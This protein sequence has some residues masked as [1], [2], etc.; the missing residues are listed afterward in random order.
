MEA[1]FQSD[2]INLE[3]IGNVAQYE[4]QSLTSSYK[5]HA[6]SDLEF[7]DPLNFLADLDW[8]SQSLEE[9][10]KFL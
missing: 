1:G 5:G 6:E 4:S 8:P 7:S 10:M 2:S 9:F 3:D